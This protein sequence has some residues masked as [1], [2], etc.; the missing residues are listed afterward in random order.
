MRTLC[1]QPEVGL[2]ARDS[3]SGETWLIQSQDALTGL[4]HLTNFSRDMW[5]RCV[6]EQWRIESI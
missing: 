4:Y 1:T 6:G 2:Y 3:W 5:S